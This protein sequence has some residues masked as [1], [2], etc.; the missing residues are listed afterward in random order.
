MA[1]QKVELRKIRDFSENF[2]D[3][4]LFIRQNL[5]PLLTSFIGIA[6]IFM[7]AYSIVSE[8]FQRNS[9][10]IFRGVL[11][12]GAAA[13]SGFNSPFAFLFSGTYFLVLLLAW[14]N[15]VAMNVV[16]T[17]Y[18]KLYDAR[19]GSAPGIEDVWNEF[20]K[21]FLKVLLYTIPIT[22]L[23]VIAFL[24]CLAPGI[25]LSVVLAPFA[26]VLIVGD[27]TFSGAWNRCFAIIKENFWQ[28]LGIYFLVYLICAFS[29]GI[30]SLIVGGIAGAISYL[31]THDIGTTVGVVTSVLNI[32]SYVFY[33]I[34][35]VSVNLNYY[36]LV[37][38]HDGIGIM[39]RL[40]TLGQT[41][42]DFDNTKEQY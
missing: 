24:F 41:G 38:K 12:G 31:T 6:G 2:S 4:F 28:T 11:N 23:T 29:G 32:F 14:A 42:S 30:I 27:E 18:M 34:L 16:V 7:L 8:V 25:Y 40:D 3:T 21:Y 10:S 26:I 19:Q 17:C 9:M 13:G 1:E 37:E 39:R 36:S 5:K 35:Y 22:L 20:K 33:V 15:F